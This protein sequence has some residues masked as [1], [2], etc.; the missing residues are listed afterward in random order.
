MGFRFRKSFKIAPGIRLNLGKSGVSTSIGVRGAH[1]TLGP[2]GA[3]TTVGIPGTGMSWTETSSGL[4]RPRSSQVEDVQQLG[5]SSPAGDT[6]KAK[7]VAIVLA[8]A[9][10]VGMF[11]AL[12][13]VLTAP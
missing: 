2:R 4:R 1:V 6:N 12:V 5:D 7:A 8:V 11:M 3:R 13:L 9:L 10:A